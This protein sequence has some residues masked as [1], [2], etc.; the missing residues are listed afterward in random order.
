MCANNPKTSVTI[1]DELLAH[2][3]NVNALDRVGL[4]VGSYVSTRHQH[5]AK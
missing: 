4:I 1:I 5:S 3:A 2:H